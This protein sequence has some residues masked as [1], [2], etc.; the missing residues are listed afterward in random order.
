MTLVTPAH[1]RVAWVLAMARK[2]KQ[3]TRIIQRIK[4]P[5]RLV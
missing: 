1:S 3:L 4:V 5:S 2:M